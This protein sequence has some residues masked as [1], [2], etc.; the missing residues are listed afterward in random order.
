VASLPEDLLLSLERV[1]DEWEIAIAEKG[2]EAT[3]SQKDDATGARK[4]IKV[5]RG[6]D[7]ATK[8]RTVLD[9]SD[10]YRILDAIGKAVEREEKKRSANAVSRPDLNRI[11]HELWR[12]IDARVPDDVVKA[13]IREDW[14]RVRL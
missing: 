10:A 6:Q 13:S 3:A 14:L 5:L 12:S 9:L 4:F 2:S 1:V 8:P 11:M 7:D